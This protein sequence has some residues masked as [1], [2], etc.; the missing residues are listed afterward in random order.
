MANV[1]HLAYPLR[2]EQGTPVT[3][4]Q[5]TPDDIVDCVTALLAC[6]LY[7]RIEQPDF[8]L[9]DQAFAEPGANLTEIKAAIAR[10]EPRAKATAE[11]APTEAALLD[12]VRITAEALNQ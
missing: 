8:G 2:Y 7:H 9:A 4:E 1:P 5:D 3:N 10:W 11:H 12:N 6:P